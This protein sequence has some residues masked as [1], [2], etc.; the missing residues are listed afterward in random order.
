MNVGY[1][2][3]ISPQ[4]LLPISISTQKKADYQFNGA[5]AISGILKVNGTPMIPR[6]VANKIVEKVRLSK[7]HEGS[8]IDNLQIAGPGFVNIL[9]QTSFVRDQVLSILK[10]GVRPPANM[11]KN[12]NACKERVVIDFSSP[13]IAKEMHVGHLRSTIIGKNDIS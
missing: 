12:T 7:D 6:D 9:L 11:S 8:I 4:Y 13:N 5:M 3:K 10:N 1:N 2:S